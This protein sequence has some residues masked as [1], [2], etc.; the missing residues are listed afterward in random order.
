MTTLI[1]TSKSFI[2]TVTV[3][4]T[5]FVSTSVKDARVGLP[6]PNPSFMNCDYGVNKHI[7]DGLTNQ[8]TKKCVTT[9]VF[10]SINFLNKQTMR[11]ILCWKSDLSITTW[12]N[13][14]TQFCKDQSKITYCEKNKKKQGKIIEKE[15]KSWDWII[16]F[17]FAWQTVQ[18]DTQV[19]PL[20]VIPS[21]QPVPRWCWSGPMQVTEGSR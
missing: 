6:W 20:L 17:A 13:L 9:T 18:R 19:L 1:Q 3:F 4:V 11:T 10:C 15:I 2:N 12:S 21:V 16:A 8:V 7:I 14:I 5:W